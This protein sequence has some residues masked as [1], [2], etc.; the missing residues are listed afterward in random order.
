MIRRILVPVLCLALL[1]A[2]AS[3]QSLR[4]SIAPAAV[5]QST[6]DWQKQ[7]DTAKNRK[8]S[9]K[10][11]IFIGLGASSVGFL[12]MVA[13]PS[14]VSCPTSATSVSSCSD[15]SGLLTLGL[16]TNLAGDGVFVWGLVEFFDANGEMNRL[17]AHRPA[18]KSATTFA[19]SDHQAITIGNGAQKTLSYGVSW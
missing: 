8:D 2:L 18:G 10:K 3:A 5:Q 9:G 14:S 11:K 13:A 1:P 15:G 6:A 19:L 17:D 7:Y 12:L 4:A 16:L